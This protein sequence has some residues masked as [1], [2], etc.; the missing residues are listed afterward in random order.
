VSGASHFAP[1]SPARAPSLPLGEWPDVGVLHVDLD[2]L[3]QT[4]LTAVQSE[5]PQLNRMSEEL[6][7][8][9][10]KRLRPALL[11]LAAQT[12]TADESLLLPVAAA[13]ELLH[14]ASLYH[15]DIMD[16]AATR[17]GAPSANA[18][19]GNMSAAAAGTHLLA[20]AMKLLAPLPPEV[21]S[22]VAE[23]TLTVCTG[24][25]R[26]T[27][28]AYDLGLDEEEHLR[29][30]EMKTATLIELP[31]RLGAQ[32]ASAHPRHVQALST[33]GR[34]LGIAFQ[35]TDDA[36]DLTGEATGLGKPTG[37][38]LREGIYAHSVLAALRLDPRGRLATILRRSALR[39]TDV[40]EAISVTRDSGALAV[41]HALAARHA[42]L[43]A[44]EALR[45]LPDSPTRSSL[46]SLASHAVTRR[47]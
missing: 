44:A 11:I 35:L 14:A 28:H 43:A 5:D 6:I 12:G 31:C 32:L 47:R 26:E 21:V 22:A 2:R 29:I 4:M 25:L 13:I 37:T 46:R 8:R 16:R 20:C 9:G 17:R 39:A 10:G 41:T 42:E 30:I 24:Q 27:Q 33:Y 19:W 40:A 36:L 34:H 3:D 7:T 18:L 23:A 38:D 15:D 1:E 45:S